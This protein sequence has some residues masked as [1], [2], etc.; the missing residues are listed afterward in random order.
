MT[1][2]LGIVAGC[3]VNTDPPTPSSLDVRIEFTGHHDNVNADWSG[4]KI[5][6][7]SFGCSANSI[8]DTSASMNLIGFTAIPGLIK[9]FDKHD[10]IR[11]GL[12]EFTVTAD[13]GAQILQ[14][15]C[16]VE[17]SYGG[18]INLEVKEGE[19]GCTRSSGGFGPVDDPSRDIEAVSIVA[20]AVVGKGEIVTIDTTARNHSAFNEE[21]TMRLRDNTATGT[22]AGVI[23]PE[24]Y[25]ITGLVPNNEV[26]QTFTWDTTTADLG[27]HEIIFD[28]PVLE[29]EQPN[30][31]NNA[32]SVEVE[33]IEH[34]VSVSNPAIVGPVISGNVYNV[35]VSL[36]NNGGVQETVT[37]SLEDVPTAGPVVTIGTSQ[38]ITLDKAGLANDTKSHDFLW[39]TTGVPGGLHNLTANIPVLATGEINTV[40]NNGSTT[41]FVEY[42]DLEVTS[43]SATAAENVG[44]PVP[45]AVVI[46]NNGNI[47]ESN[48]VVTLTS[49]PPGGGTPVV[50][51]TQIVPLLA[52]G[53]STTVNFTWD[54]ACISP[55]GGYILGASASVPN[56]ALVANDSA[57][58]T[59]VTLTIDHEL[60]VTII[61]DPGTVAQG[62]LLLYQVDLTNN[63]S[64]AETGIDVTFTATGP[65]AS[66][67]TRDPRLP[68]DLACGETVGLVFAWP[69]PTLGGGTFTLTATIATAV[70]GDDPVG[71]MPNT[72]TITV[73]VP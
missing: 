20:P 51:A 58:S 30:T 72:S 7:A 27:I 18:V 38:A 6:D 26:T 45:A 28:V 44:V 47:D 25:N 33:I 10:D 1:V 60:G 24:D 31:T 22:G 9:T 12:W 15:T 54:T 53:A 69:T 43:V 52:A 59:P 8:G 4:T 50:V 32:R 65:A 55:E 34:D 40:N 42:H 68:I 16:T 5:G 61:T 48:F 66:A 63:N 21:F 37:V 35:S 67:P 36:S 11:C 56:D 71:P 29:Y 19:N 13:N 41:V 17:V 57:Q 14:E 3:T 70:A 73:I 2:M 49:E 23:I 46:R 39:D 64:V 62:T